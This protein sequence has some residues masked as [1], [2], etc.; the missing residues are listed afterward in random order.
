L[1]KEKQNFIAGCFPSLLSAQPAT[2]A[3]GS[4]SPL[5][6]SRARPTP[7][8]GPVKPDRPASARSLTPVADCWPRSQSLSSF[9][10]ARGHAAAVTVDG[11]LTDDE[12]S[13]HRSRINNP[14][15][16]TRTPRTS[17]WHE[18]DLLQHGGG[19]TAAMAATVATRPATRRAKRAYSA[20]AIK[21]RGA[22]R[23]GAHS[24]RVGRL[25][26]DG[27]ALERSVHGEAITV[28]LLS[29]V[30]K[31]VAVG[32]CRRGEAKSVAPG[33]AHTPYGAACEG[34]GAVEQ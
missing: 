19:L 20:V 13:E 33:A 7:R 25:G 31:T 12:P 29:A 34:N 27:D 23:S 26:D 28:A 30:E 4:R 17:L 14:N 3:R 32:G 8:L 22:S 16:I 15:S 11:E 6:R 10:P 2:C 5:P 18:L 21:V 1:K 24:D 9:S